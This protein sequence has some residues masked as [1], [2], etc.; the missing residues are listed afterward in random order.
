MNFIRRS[1]T[2]RYWHGLAAGA[3]VGAAA[4][5]VANMAFGTNGTYK[6]AFEDGF[7]AGEITAYQQAYA[8]GEQA[9]AELRASLNSYHQQ[10]EAARERFSDLTPQE[11]A[12]V[13]GVAPCRAVYNDTTQARWNS[14][15]SNDWKN[16]RL[17][18]LAQEAITRG[19]PRQR[20]AVMLGWLLAEN[21]ALDEEVRGDGG[22]SIGLCQ[23]H[24][25]HRLCSRGYKAQVEQCLG[26]FIAYT[27]N[28]PAD[29]NNAEIAHR[30]R[31]RHNPQ[32][33]HWYIQSVLGRAN[34]V[35]VF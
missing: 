2:S 5:S 29:A 1:T 9:I 12:E 21:G 16:A 24:T 13:Y 17:T 15:Q 33:G 20:L 11:C 3:L 10:A 32:A 14:P 19:I 8:E 25:G 34:E 28:L 4:L 22:A 23:C 35:S 6:G 27:A 31:A 7:A 30:I 18:D 26:W